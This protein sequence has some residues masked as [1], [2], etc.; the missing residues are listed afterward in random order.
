MKRREKTR[1]IKADRFETENTD[2]HSRVRDEFLKIADENKKR[3]LVLNSTLSVEILLA[4][5]IE[6]LKERGL[7]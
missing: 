4:S 6:C 1:K 7:I 3:F 5:T 2:F